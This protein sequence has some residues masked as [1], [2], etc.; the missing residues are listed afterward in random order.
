MATHTKSISKSVKSPYVVFSN[1]TSLS[2]DITI[3]DGDI[4]DFRNSLLRPA[5]RVSII[6][7]GTYSVTLKVNT[8]ENT[9]IHNQYEADTSLEITD[10]YPMSEFRLSTTTRLQFDFPEG[11]AVS[12]IKIVDVTGAGDASNNMTVIGF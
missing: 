7:L 11:F 8:S 12:M 2:D 1:D 10:I 5:K 9:H 3:A 6:L 4:L